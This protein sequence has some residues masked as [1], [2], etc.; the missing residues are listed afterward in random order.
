M[1]AMTKTWAAL[2]VAAAPALAH[3]ETTAAKK[4]LTLERGRRT[5]AAAEARKAGAR[6]RCTHA[7]PTS[8]T[9]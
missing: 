3:A 4:T 9:C 8:S 6:W 2:L 1:N 5:I 7:T